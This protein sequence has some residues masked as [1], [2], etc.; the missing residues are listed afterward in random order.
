VGTATT[1][2][3]AAAPPRQT[4]VRDAGVTGCNGINA[5][6]RS[7]DGSG[8]PTPTQ[9]LPCNSDDNEWLR[10]Q[11]RKWKGR[12]MEDDQTKASGAF[13]LFGALRV[14]TQLI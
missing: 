3:A 12:A 5:A 11:H 10:G 6:T 4:A 8:T 13:F 14:F 1:P 2:A 9:L 7:C